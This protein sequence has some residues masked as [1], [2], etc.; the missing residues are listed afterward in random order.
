MTLT[1]LQEQGLKIA[2]ERFKNKEKYTVIAGLAGSGKTYL[3]KKIIEALNLKDEEIIVG[4]F[5]GKAAFKLQEVGFSEAKT[6]HKLRYNTRKVGSRF[7]HIKKPKSEFDGIKLILIDEISM[8]PNNILKDFAELDIHILMLGDPGQLPPVGQ[9]NGMLKKPHIF[10]T[11]I[12]RQSEDNSIIRLAHDIRNGIKIKPFSDNN[13]MM[14][15]QEELDSSILLWADQVLCG[16]NATR[17]NFNHAIR[18]GL[19]FTNPLPEVNDRIIIVKNN[20]EHINREG[21]SL[22][23]GLTGIVTQAGEIDKSAEN[24]GKT[25]GRTIKLGNL[26]FV[27]DFGE[28]EFY[29]PKYD[30]HYLLTNGRNSSYIMN[31]FAKGP[32]KINYI[33]YGYCFTVHKSQGS[34]YDKVLGIDEPMRGTDYQKWLYTMV[35]RAKEKLII[36][37]NKRGN[38]WDI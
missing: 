18:E 11:E 27:P 36:A 10:L 38:L 34:E 7:V 6:L 20:W 5:T 22:I 4:S 31:Q 35:T 37:Y 30:A 13:I 25:I 1:K 3:T 24:I 16:T 29:L 15:P 12:V 9:D 8:V 28:G 23:N 2:I 14:I 21:L 19:G 26:Y 17:S 32:D 33:D